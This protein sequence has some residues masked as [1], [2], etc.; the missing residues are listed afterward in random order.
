MREGKSPLVTRHEV[1]WLRS[2]IVVSLRL[3]ETLWLAFSTAVGIEAYHAQR[4]AVGARM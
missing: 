2:G 1:A 4:V 3:S